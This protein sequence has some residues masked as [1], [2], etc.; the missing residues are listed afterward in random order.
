MAG[1]GTA[2]LAASV[3]AAGGLG[4]ISCAAMQPQLAMKT[5]QR[6]RALTGKPININFFCHVPAK[7]DAD[8]ERTW[9]DRLSP[10]YREL[11]IDPVLPH[12]HVD[13]APFG[14]AMC[15]V[16]E[17]SVGPFKGHPAT[18]HPPLYLGANSC[19]G[20]TRSAGRSWQCALGSR[21]KASFPF[22]SSGSSASRRDNLGFPQEVP[23]RAQV[24][25]RIRR[26]SPLGC[27]SSRTRLDAIASLSKS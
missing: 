1:F 23:E 13:I 21:T 7:V 3:C 2:E 9:H 27:P 4:S 11:G 20:G 15:A 17:K 16:V 14:N 10:Y 12:P 26:A 5:I 25:P 6:L 18:K 22:T 8:R 19:R 24:P